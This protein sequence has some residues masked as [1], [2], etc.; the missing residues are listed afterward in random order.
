MY[1]EP[2][3][4]TE[5]LEEINRQLNELEIEKKQLDRMYMKILLIK[6]ELENILKK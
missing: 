5:L 1:K 4:A 2:Q 6:T 3:N